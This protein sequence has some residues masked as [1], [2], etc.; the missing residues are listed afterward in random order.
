MSYRN[1]LVLPYLCLIQL[2]SIRDLNAT[3][4]GQ[5]FVEMELLLQLCQL[6]VGKVRPARVVC[7]V[8]QKTIRGR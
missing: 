4:P 2:Q 3:C 5:V 6:L 7:A 8:H 1:P